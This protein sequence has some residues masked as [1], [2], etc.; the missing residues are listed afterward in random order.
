MTPSP[1]S[2]EEAREL[3]CD[4]GMS[5]EA[6]ERAEMVWT[7]LPTRVPWTSLATHEKAL[8]CHT[9]ARLTR[10]TPDLGD[11]DELVEKAAKA[12]FAVTAIQVGR[13]PNGFEQLSPK[14]RELALEATRAALE[15][16]GL[17]ALRAALDKKD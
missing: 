8:V 4:S 9:L 15:A 17:I 10:P 1:S 3:S 12:F 11:V 6:A 5:G 13:D 14:S 2:Q 16:T 7:N